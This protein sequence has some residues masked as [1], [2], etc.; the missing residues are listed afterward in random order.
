[1]FNLNYLLVIICIIVG[2]L[3]SFGLF[4]I[5]ILVQSFSNF[6]YIENIEKVSGFECG[7]APYI[8]NSFQINFYIVCLI[9]LLFDLELIL[10][11]P[12]VFIQNLNFYIFFTV[13]ITLWLLIF[14][15]IYEVEKKILSFI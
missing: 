14:G 10:L 13:V 15:L 6:N 1:M 9:F 3:F 4:F 2:F 11:F 8:Q 5:Y 12:L 7:F